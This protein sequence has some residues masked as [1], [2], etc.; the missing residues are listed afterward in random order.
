[1]FLPA[2]KYQVSKNCNPHGSLLEWLKLVHFC[3]TKTIETLVKAR[4]LV[5]VALQERDSWAEL[6]PPKGGCFEEG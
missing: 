6:M 3:C 2:E 4:A 5:P 1:M